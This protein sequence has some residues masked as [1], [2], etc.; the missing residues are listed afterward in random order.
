MRAF[1]GRWTG[2]GAI[3]GSGDTEVMTL[4]EGEYMDSEVVVTD[5]VQVELLQ[6]VYRSGDTASIWYKTGDSEVN[7]LAATWVLY[8]GIFGSLGYVQV[9][10]VN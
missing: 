10:M 3:S 1:S 5:V 6:N 7:C 4:D 8:A 2:T 9:R